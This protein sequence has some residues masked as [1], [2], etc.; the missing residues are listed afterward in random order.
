MTD[1]KT[2]RTEKWMK[3]KVYA[4]C[5]GYMNYT[6]PVICPL[7]R[8]EFVGPAKTTKWRCKICKKKQGIFH[9]LCAYDCMFPP[10]FI[11]KYGGDLYEEDIISMMREISSEA[12]VNNT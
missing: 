10:D 4:E 7:S 9:V 8:A 1:E 2:K 11:D 3:G 6:G 5:K 12:S